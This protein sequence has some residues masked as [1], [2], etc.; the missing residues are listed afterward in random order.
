M[1]IWRLV[2]IFMLLLGVGLGRGVMET[3]IL[4]GWALFGW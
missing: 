2:D 3:L 4:D 1:L